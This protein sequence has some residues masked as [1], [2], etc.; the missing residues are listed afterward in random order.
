G[1]PSKPDGAVLGAGGGVVAK[2]DPSTPRLTQRHP[3][4]LKARPKEHWAGVVAQ[5]A[6][7]PMAGNDEAMA[8]LKR[9]LDVREPLYRQADTIV[10]TSGQ[11]PEESLRA[12]HQILRG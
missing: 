8:D 4:G 1:W 2:E 9:I 7:R 3:V 12:L 10:D 6:R 5:G 11:T